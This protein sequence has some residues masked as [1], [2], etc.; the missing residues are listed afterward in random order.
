MNE[1]AALHMRKLFG[2]T[3]E[4]SCGS[5]SVSKRHTRNAQQN[6]LVR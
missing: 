4:S 5:W 2:P 1:V 6:R 3:L